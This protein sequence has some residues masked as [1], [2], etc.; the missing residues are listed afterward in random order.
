MISINYAALQFWGT[1]AQGILSFGFAIYVKRASKDTATKERIDN[2]E[3]DLA[4]RCRKHQE[5][6]TTLEADYR[7]MP[8]QKD[9]AELNANISG[10][11]GR[12][13]GINRAVDLLNQHHMGRQ[14]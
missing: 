14:D 5:R 12:L 3:K 7:H 13:S 6:T 9:L 8:G 11:S 2:L 10:L 4:E 1:I